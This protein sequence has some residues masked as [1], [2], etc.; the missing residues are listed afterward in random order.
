MFN[1]RSMSEKRRRRRGTGSEDGSDLSETELDTKSPVGN[2]CLPC[3]HFSNWTWDVRE[4]LA[5]GIMLRSTH[6]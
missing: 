3:N 1:F 6:A 5:L 2:C 4:I